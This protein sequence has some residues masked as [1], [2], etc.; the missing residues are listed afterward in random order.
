MKLSIRLVC[1]DQSKRIIHY[2][3][4]L[5]RWPINERKHGSHL[6]PE[7]D[8]LGEYSEDVCGHLLVISFNL[9]R[10]NLQNKPVK[11]SMDSSPTVNNDHL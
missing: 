10:V 2:V 8:K 7:L 6:V 1:H 5:H 9:Q 3:P 4:P 11:H